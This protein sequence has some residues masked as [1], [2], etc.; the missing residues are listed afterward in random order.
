MIDNLQKDSNNILKL[1]E[2]VSV[3]RFWLHSSALLKSGAIGAW[4]PADIWQWVQATDPDKGA[5][6][7]NRKKLS[8]SKC[9]TGGKPSFIDEQYQIRG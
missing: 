5:K 3:F 1:C 4:L 7:L 6:L 9:L 8:K 2:F